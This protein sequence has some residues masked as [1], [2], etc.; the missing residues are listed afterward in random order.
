MVEPV[1]STEMADF[2]GWT[3]QEKRTVPHK[4]GESTYFLFNGKGW[5]YDYDAKLIDFSGK[6][7][8]SIS[9]MDLDAEISQ[10]YYQG[11]YDTGGISHPEVLPNYTKWVRKTKKKLQMSWVQQTDQKKQCENVDVSSMHNQQYIMYDP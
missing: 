2:M 11:Y 10:S 8:R 5:L 7:Q 1:E 4:Y 6:N 9:I 3:L